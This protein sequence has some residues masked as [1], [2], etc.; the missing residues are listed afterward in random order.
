MAGKIIVLGIPAI[1]RKLA[2]IPGIVQRKIARK[3]MRDGMKVMA[4]EVRR[5][6]PVD[7]GLTKANVKVR[8]AKK[9]RRGDIEIDVK[10]SGNPGLYKTYAGGTKQVFYPAAVTFGNS[11][12]RANPFMQRSFAS[13]GNDCKNITIAEI[14]SE[15]NSLVP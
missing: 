1:D 14:T 5:Q 8:A 4:D 6:A 3:A 12:T 15:V 13:R 2:K 10:I 7:T 11:T 9:R